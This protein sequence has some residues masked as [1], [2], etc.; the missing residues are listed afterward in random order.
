LSSVFL[1]KLEYYQ[2]ILILTT[3]LIHT[4]DEAF[5]SRISVA[6]AYEKLDVAA[7]ERVWRDFIEEMDERKVNKKGLLAEVE[8]WGKLNLNARQIR[9]I[10]M[11]AETI[12]LD[13]ISFL[14]AED[15]EDIIRDTDAFDRFFK[16]K[17]ESN[18]NRVLGSSRHRKD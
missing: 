4:I 1:R 16:K 18:K 10:L 14:Q 17:E 15:V 9:N 5:R 7:C 6:Y 3:N 2:G 8:R 11:T 13:Q 12:M